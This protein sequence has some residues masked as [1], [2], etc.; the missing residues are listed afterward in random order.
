VIVAAGM[1]SR[2]GGV[3]K[4][5]APL[6]LEPVIVHAVR[7]FQQ[8]ECIREIVVV[9]R[10]D[11]IVEV[12]RVLH[13]AGLDKVTQVVVGGETRTVSVMIGLD[14][15]SKKTKLAAIHDGARPFVTTELIERTVRVAAESGAAAPAVPVK[16]TIK[17]AH[18][19]IVTETPD[20][21]TLFAV[22]T[23]QV[24]DF[25]LLRG[26]MVKAEADGLTATDDCA[27]VEHLGMSVRLTEGD[28]ENIKLT[29]PLDLALAQA[30]AEGRNG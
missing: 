20:R 18:Q 7:P 27:I 19:G 22:Q 2:M 17:V 30:I 1:A 4:V 5:L 15:V 23:P 13:E 10:E 14:C 16:D 3:D 21:S 26:A 25:D 28:E 9:T 6:G 12:S 29:T 11:L 24:F 8:S